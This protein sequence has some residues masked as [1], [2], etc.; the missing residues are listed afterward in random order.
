MRSKVLQ[1]F[2]IA[3]RKKIQNWRLSKSRDFSK[4]PFWNIL[5]LFWMVKTEKRRVGVVGA[6][7]HP[8]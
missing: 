2:L 7:D 3:I 6:Q 1:V 5:F 4:F 8:K